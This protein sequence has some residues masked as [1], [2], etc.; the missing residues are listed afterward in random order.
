MSGT[1]SHIKSKVRSLVGKDTFSFFA[2]SANY[3][4]STL[5]I[6]GMQFLTIPIMTAI[7]SPAEYGILG[8]YTSIVSIFITVICLNFDSATVRFYYEKPGEYEAFF[9]SVNLFVTFAGAVMIAI[10]YLFRFQLASY[11]GVDSNIVMFATVTPYFNNCYTMYLST[12]QAQKNSKKYMKVTLIQRLS[13]LAL[14]I[15]LLYALK[16][17]KYYGKIYAEIA[18]SLVAFFVLFKRFYSGAKIKWEYVSYAAKIGIPLIPHVLSS[19]ILSYF[20]RI[21]INNISGNSEAGIFS[22]AEDIGMVMMIVSMSFNK[23]WTPIF[24]QKMNEKDYS[25]INTQTKQIIKTSIGIAIFLLFFAKEMVTIMSN[26]RYYAALSVVPIIII[27]KAFG[28]LYTIY[29]HFSDYY[30]KTLYISLGTL[31][32]GGSNIILNSIFI[33]RFGVMAGA[34]NTMICSILLFV[35]H[36]IVSRLILKVRVIPVLPLLKEYIWLFIAAIIYFVGLNFLSTLTFIIVR[37]VYLLLIVYSL[38]GK[39]VI[40]SNKKNI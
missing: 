1:L 13:C 28:P 30:K 34:V 17:D 10:I 29:S 2:H 6:R 37:V 26:E 15:L 20:A 4:T 24:Y 18:V 33:P 3:M 27:G 21:M 16:E 12:L 38:I 25:G 5:L 39:N 7:L 35:C 9:K 8:I 40:H 14:T 11:F 32:V 23:S 31:F 22:F 36:F 19:F